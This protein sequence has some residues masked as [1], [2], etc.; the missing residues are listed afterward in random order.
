MKNFLFA[1]NSFM[2]LA[3]SL[4]RYFRYLLNTE[5]KFIDDDIFV[6]PDKIDLLY[7]INE[8]SVLQK[9]LSWIHKNKFNS[10]RLR[11]LGC[12]THADINL[13]MVETLGIQ[14]ENSFVISRRIDQ[15]NF[16]FISDRVKLFFKGHGEQS[17]LGC[18][19]WVNYY[20]GNYP[21]MA[22][23]NDYSPKEL[24]ET[25]LA[26]GIQ[27]WEEFTR[28]FS[29]YVPILYVS[30][31]D[32]QVNEIER[33]IKVVA[34]DIKRIEFSDSFHTFDS[35]TIKSLAEITSFIEEMAFQANR[36]Q[37]ETYTADH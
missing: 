37:N 18:I 26:P 34:E 6:E 12:D 30:G 31:W 35:G 29:K 36:K 28:R 23:S 15:S 9:C 5:L 17:L 24:N 11:I 27:N 2:P 10:N 8:S 22:K 21:A 14:I 1:G 20:L 7:T 33:C 16:L 13:L 32:K 3:R 19:G 25:F 4:E